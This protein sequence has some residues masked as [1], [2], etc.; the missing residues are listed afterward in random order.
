MSTNCE[1]QS[2]VNYVSAGL[3]EAP[4][5]AF[6]RLELRLGDENDVARM[7][8]DD[9]L[10]TETMDDIGYGHA[11]LTRGALYAINVEFQESTGSAALSVEWSSSEIKRQPIA[12]ALLYPRCRPLKGSPFSYEAAL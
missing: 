12:A 11:Y 6:F 8:I 10:V 3:L 5:T 4:E 7:F 2:T 1:F 9:V